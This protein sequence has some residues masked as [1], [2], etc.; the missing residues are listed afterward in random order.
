MAFLCT[1]TFLADGSGRAVDGGKYLETRLILAL[2]KI[3]GQKGVARKRMVP[4]CPKAEDSSSTTTVER[5]GLDFPDAP[6]RLSKGRDFLRDDWKEIWKQMTVEF[7]DEELGAS[8]YRPKRRVRIGPFFTGTKF[9]EKG[10]KRFSVVDMQKVLLHE[11]LHAA[12]TI[13]DR[14]FHHGMISQVLIGNLGYPEPANPASV[15]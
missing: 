13:E 10:E 11:F 3:S 1:T 15:D 14:Q 12:F 7:S 2:W 6:Q 9:T 4:G 5:A 8:I